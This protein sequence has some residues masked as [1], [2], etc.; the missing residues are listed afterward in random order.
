MIAE[1]TGINVVLFESPINDKG[2]HTGKQGWFDSA[3]RTLY[4]D[5]KA[6]YGN[7]EATMRAAGHELTHV[8]QK[9]APEFYENTYKPAVI[10]ALYEGNEGTMLDLVQEQIRIAKEN[11]KTMTESQAMFEVIADASERMLMGDQATR[12]LLP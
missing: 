9:F 7:E 3:K 11:G 10:D 6:G 12:S 4:L 5:V 8:I 1:S 2:E